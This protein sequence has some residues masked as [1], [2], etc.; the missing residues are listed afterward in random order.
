MPDFSGAWQADFERS[1]MRGPAPRRMQVEIDHRE[2]HLEQRVTVTAE[3]GEEQRL[4]FRFQTDGNETENQIG[5]RV[6]RTQ[7]HWD[8]AELV[9]ES[10]VETPAGDLRLEDHWELSADG[11]T[12]TM[13]HRHDVLDG[14]SVVF[15]PAVPNPT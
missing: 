10:H 2:P 4:V 9:I 8:R 11:Q 12:L 14:Q 5:G 1:V 13:T 6:A 15:R 7:A 3:N